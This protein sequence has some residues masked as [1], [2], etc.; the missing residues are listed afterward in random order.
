MK[1][2]SNFHAPHMVREYQIIQTDFIDLCRVRNK[3]KWYDR[4]SVGSVLIV[5]FALVLVI[6]MLMFLVS[7]W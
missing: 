5:G 3:T 2:T 6:M 7:I 4:W 1:K